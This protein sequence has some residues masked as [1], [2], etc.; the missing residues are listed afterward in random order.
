MKSIPGKEKYTVAAAF[1]LLL[2]LL[3]VL[4]AVLTG[5]GSKTPVLFKDT[6][7]DAVPDPDEHVQISAAGE[8]EIIYAP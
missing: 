8:P 3:A 2:V 1:V 5:C 7:P 6:L 4:S